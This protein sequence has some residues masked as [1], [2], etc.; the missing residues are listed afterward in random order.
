MGLFKSTYTII[1]ENTTKFYLELKKNYSDRFDKEASILATAGT[2]DAQWY[3]LKEETISINY[4]LHLAKVSLKSPL[5][6]KSRKNIA[7]ISF[8]VE[9]EIEIFSID[10]R[11][12]TRRIRDTVMNLLGKIEKAVLKTQDTYSYELKT[13]NDTH[14]FMTEPLFEPFRKALKIKN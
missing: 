2:L 11:L 1:A 9:L 10:T 3:V 4:L 5:D 14:N 7:L 8:I 13:V 6:I 12:D